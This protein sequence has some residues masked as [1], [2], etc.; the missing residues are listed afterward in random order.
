MNGENND[1]ELPES[2]EICP[3]LLFGNG[4]FLIFIVPIIFSWFSPFVVFDRCFKD[5]TKSFILRPS[6]MD[7]SLNMDC[8]IHLFTFHNECFTF[9]YEYNI[10]SK[11]YLWH[12]DSIR[13]RFITLF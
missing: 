2:I 12:K 5:F 10:F 4:V 13:S 11:L 9:H 6:A 1:Q 3:N 8:L 7:Y